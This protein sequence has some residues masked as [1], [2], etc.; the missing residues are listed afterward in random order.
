MNGNTVV[1]LVIGTLVLIVIAYFADGFL[2]AYESKEQVAEQVQPQQPVA[3]G[4]FVMSGDMLVDLCQSGKLPAG[5]CPP[6]TPPVSTSTC[7]CPDGMSCING[8]CWPVKVAECVYK[9]QCP[10]KDGYTVSCCE[11]ECRYWKKKSK[12][13]TPSAPAPSVQQPPKK[14]SSSEFSCTDIQ[15]EDGS[16]VVSC[17]PN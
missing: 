6:A 1:S 7:D 17:I 10:S 5:S 11:G 3:G 14:K 15:R 2:D 4:G 12:P 13:A 16:W 8:Q 9:S